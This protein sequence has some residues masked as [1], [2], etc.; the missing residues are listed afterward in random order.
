MPDA[1]AR[2]PLEDLEASETGQR[3][4]LLV[5][6]LP[7]RLRNI[8]DLVIFRGLAYHEAAE[9]LGIPIGTVKSRIHNAILHLRRVLVAPA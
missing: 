6:S 1:Q 2:N 5:D 9:V 7:T 4:R 3:L 8:L